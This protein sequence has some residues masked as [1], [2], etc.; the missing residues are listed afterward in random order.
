MNKNKSTSQEWL[1]RKQGC[2]NI[3]RDEWHGARKHHHACPW[4]LM[5]SHKQCYQGMGTSLR[6]IFNL[7]DFKSFF[8][9]IFQDNPRPKP[10]FGDN[11]GNAATMFDNVN[12]TIVPA[13]TATDAGVAGAGVSTPDFDVFPIS[14]S[15]NRFFYH[16]S[17]RLGFPSSFPVYWSFANSD[18]HPT[19]RKWFESCFSPFLTSK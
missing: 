19:N 9:T 2:F 3:R 5:L 14:D 7:R 15:A 18:A 17:S 13:D 11:W 6:E 12:C 16:S 1:V 10:E 4:S 8:A